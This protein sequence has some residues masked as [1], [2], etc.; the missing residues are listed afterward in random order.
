MAQHTRKDIYVIGM[1]DG[2]PYK[3]R[4]SERHGIREKLWIASCPIARDLHGNYVVTIDSLLYQQVGWMPEFKFGIVKHA[5]GADTP[6]ERFY[7][8]DAARP[9]VPDDDRARLIDVVV[10]S[11]E[12]LLGRAR[13][14]EVLRQIK[15]PHKSSR[16]VHDR[17]TEVFSLYGY[18]VE[19]RWPDKADRRWVHVRRS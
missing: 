19:F 17:I 18:A 3:I 14:L 6:P 11:L 8:S 10:A 4:Y 2:P 16:R 15:E 12:G 13:P 1:L 9:Y 5:I 7:S